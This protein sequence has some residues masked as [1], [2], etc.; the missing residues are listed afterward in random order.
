MHVDFE[1]KREKEEKRFKKI[2]RQGFFGVC[3]ISAVPQFLPYSIGDQVASF[4]ED[5]AILYRSKVESSSV[6]KH[7]RNKEDLEVY[8]PSSNL[9]HFHSI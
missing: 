1:M 9:M 6:F 4:L 2:G 3:G 7:V 5:L 8:T